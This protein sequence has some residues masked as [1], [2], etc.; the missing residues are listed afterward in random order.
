MIIS[1]KYIQ[2]SV[3]CQSTHAFEL[4]QPVKQNAVSLKK[5]GGSGGTGVNSQYRLQVCEPTIST[6]THQTHN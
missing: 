6:L 5:L 2:L 3:S 1:Q 4:N